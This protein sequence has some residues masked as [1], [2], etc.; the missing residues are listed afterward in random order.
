MQV[1]KPLLGL[2]L[3]LPAIGTVKIDGPR[4]SIVLG[5]TPPVQPTAEEVKAEPP[6]SPS[7]RPGATLRAAIRDGA[8]V[9]RSANSDEPVIDVENLSVTLSLQR[10]GANRELVVDP[11]RPL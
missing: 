10:A 11:P 9:I 5:D 3:S 1:E 4:T 6:K 8:I 2:L 7:S